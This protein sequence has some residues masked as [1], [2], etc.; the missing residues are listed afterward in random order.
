[1][2]TLIFLAL[3]SEVDSLAHNPARGPSGSHSDCKPLLQELSNSV[4]CIMQG[5][6]LYALGITISLDRSSKAEA[7]ELAGMVQTMFK[8]NITP[9]LSVHSVCHGSMAIPLTSRKPGD[10]SN[11]QPRVIAPDAACLYED[12]SK[13]AVCN[14]LWR[15]HL[16]KSDP[17]QGCPM[18]SGRAPVRPTE[19]PD[20]TLALPAVD[21]FTSLCKNHFLEFPKLYDTDYCAQFVTQYC[22]VGG[23]EHIRI[24]VSVGSPNRV[25]ASL[26]ISSQGVI[27][28]SPPLQ[29]IEPGL[30]MTGLWETSVTFDAVVAL[31]PGCHNVEVMFSD[32]VELYD[33]QARLFFSPL[34][35]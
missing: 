12:V 10:P 18:S 17:S 6:T 5:N 16:W 32:Y 30:Q 22:V 11:W 2:N 9:Q 20:L 29:N 25:P 24:V 26:K 34:P 13:A 31:P 4:Q 35:W 7:M 8:A 14:P 27:I 33:G 19:A 28:A 21:L 15:V 23:S 1:M 3:V